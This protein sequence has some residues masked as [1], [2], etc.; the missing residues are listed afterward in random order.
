MKL[1]L[2]IDGEKKTF[3]LPDFIPAR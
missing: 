1:T 2:Q 3:H